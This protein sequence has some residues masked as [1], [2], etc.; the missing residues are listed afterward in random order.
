M[1]VPRPRLPTLAFAAGGLGFALGVAGGATWM[2]PGEL[3]AA[4]DQLGVA[5]P[6]GHP[7]WVMLGKLAAL[8]P[9]GE[10]GFRI[11]LLSAA[12]MGAALAAMV[13]IAGRL[14]PRAPAATALAALLLALAPALV[15]NAH[16]VEVYGPTLALVGWSLYA[17]LAFLDGGA[18]R[19]LL[20]A[21]LL[22]A[23]AATIHPLIAAAALAAPAAA[24]IWA[25]RSRL[26][27][28]AGPAAILALLAAAS[29]LLLPVRA[30]AADPPALLWGDPGSA[31]AIW[32]LVTGA[33][34][35]DNFALSSFGD[36]LAAAAAALAEGPARSLLLAGFA[37]LLL[38][39]VTG[40]RGAALLLAVAALSVAAAATQSR[41]NPDL[42]AY[43]LPALV[44]AAVGTAILADAI[45]RLAAAEGDRFR[46][47]IH[48]T[49]VIGVGLFGFCGDAAPG[50]PE[51]GDPADL[52]AH[53]EDT[54]GAMPPGPGVYVTNSDA[55]LFAAFYEQLVAGD[56]PDIAVANDALVTDSWFLAHLD[57][58]LPELYLPYIDD[59]VAGQMGER[60][61]INNL[62][63][64]RP[65]GGE[66]PAFG[67]L[68]ATHAKPLGR[69]YQML[70]FR[71]DAGPGQEA[72]PP[73]PY[74]GEIG[75][76]VARRAGVIRARYESSRDRLGGAARALGLAAPWVEELAL[77]PRADRPDLVSL[78]P[79]LTP[80]FLHAPW[81]D[82]LVIADLRWRG[83]G[84]A[85]S[86]LGPVEHHLLAAWHR[87]IAGDWE[88]GQAILAGL[89]LRED[90]ATTRMLMTLERAEQTE[91]HLRAIL[92]RRGERPGTLALLASTLANRGTD[93]SLAEAEALFE[94]AVALDPDN[95]ETSAR[96]G[97][98]RAR[99]GDK[100]GAARAW[101]RAL[102]LAPG[103]AD[104]RAWL[105]SLSE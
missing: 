34:Y 61:A 64:G 94:R 103:R 49:A 50:Q 5:H 20:L 53:F 45:A 19:H 93:E 66:V 4:A 16:R 72:R 100:A 76:R 74:R 85:A 3:A 46:L 73:P 26:R 21:A 32:D 99:R 41:L 90:E 43:L 71:G 27:R 81:I 70:L 10:V 101:T 59:G 15:Y 29:Y 63:Q 12:A 30:G 95:D 65:A 33:A 42:R 96:L 75:R 6:P 31:A 78:V 14:V 91:R 105:A 8:L 48:A 83:G 2:D 7:S 60:L 36:Q 17:A 77:L 9:I 55:T 80:V 97:V 104:V 86:A 40:L 37:G 39:A 69:G 62:R 47:A 89:G 57:R 88:E 87:L 54:V 18:P 84:P 52:E 23:L 58:R 68:R 82:A 51:L 25:G 38:G 11:G 35:R 98:V 13:A 28:L 22:G 1:K 92:D 56:R 102:E 44:A 24:L 79:A 67:E